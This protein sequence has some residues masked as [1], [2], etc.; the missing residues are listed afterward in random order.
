MNVYLIR[1][2]ETDW[3]SERKLQGQTDIPLNEYG[4]ELAE[5]TAKELKNIKFDRIFSSPLI[6]AVQTAEILRGDRKLSIITDDRIKEINFGLCE[7]TVI[8]RY[9]DEP[10]SPIW[11]FEFDTENYMPAEGG[12]TF[13]QIYERSDDFFKKCIMPLEEECENVLIVGHGCFNRT[14]L[15]PMMGRPLK[16]FWEIKLDNCAVSVIEVNNGKVQVIEQGKKYYER[17]RKPG[18]AIDVT[19]IYG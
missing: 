3:N 16:R 2:G 7:G 5:I 19:D 18:D 8:P 1:H 11:K 17:V 14:L 10:V 9:E 12:E 6:R 4:I 15:N 13:A